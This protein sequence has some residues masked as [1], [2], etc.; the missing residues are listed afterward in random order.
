MTRAQTHSECSCAYCIHWISKLAAD[1]DHDTAE[2][3]ATAN[4]LRRLEGR[5]ETMEK[6]RERRLG[7]EEVEDRKARTMAVGLGGG[8]LLGLIWQ[9]VEAILRHTGG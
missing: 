5:V 2:G 7:R 1:A 6:N 3:K 4:E 8:G 9:I